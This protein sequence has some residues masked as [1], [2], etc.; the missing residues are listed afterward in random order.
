[1]GSNRNL[2]KFVVGRFLEATL[3]CGGRE[4]NSVIQGAANLNNDTYHE[5]KEILAF[6]KDV[7]LKLRGDGTQV[8]VIT[9]EGMETLRTCRRDLQRFGKGNL[10]V[11]EIRRKYA[12]IRRTRKEKTP[13]PDSGED[14]A[15]D[16]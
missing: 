8:P 15:S 13:A 10:V 1:M 3:K 9:A 14:A 5:Y 11:E 2:D 16:S 7:E 6:T 12:E 4:A